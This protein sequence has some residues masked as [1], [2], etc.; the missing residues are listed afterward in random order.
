MFDAVGVRL[1]ETPAT[2]ERIFHLL[3]A[4]KQQQAAS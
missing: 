4:Q 1:T 3:Q 2:P